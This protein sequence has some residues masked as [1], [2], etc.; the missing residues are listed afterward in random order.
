MFLRKHLRISTMVLDSVIPQR[1]L[2]E[3]ST[4]SFDYELMLILPNITLYQCY[5]I[6]LNRYIK[7]VCNG[8]HYSTVFRTI[9]AVQ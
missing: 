1:G 7:Q 9:K 4:I 3:L 8:G 5:S 2:T 6:N